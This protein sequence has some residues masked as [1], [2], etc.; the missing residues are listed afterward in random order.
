MSAEDYTGLSPAQ[1]PGPHYLAFY[2]NALAANGIAYDVYD[3]DAHDRTA[4]DPLGVLSHYDA[5]LW[6]TGDDIVVREPDQFGGTSSA[7]RPA[8]AVL[9]PRLHERGRPCGL[10]RQERRL[11][12][13]DRMSRSTTTRSRTATARS[14]P[15]TQAPLCRPLYGS[16]DGVNDV[17]EYWLGAG[18][19]NVGA[20]ANFDDEGNF[21]NAFDVEGVDNPFAGLGWGF[22]GPGTAENQDGNLGPNSYITTSGLVP[23]DEYPQFNSWASAR[24]DRPGGPFDPHSGDNYVYSQIAD[25][26]YKRLTK[27]VTP[28]R[29]VTR[30]RSGPR[31][32]PSPTGTSCSSR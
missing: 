20:G 10:R 21:L 30:C 27:T 5:V 7:A 26:S 17:L 29:R 4:P 11:G 28:R 22:N 25:V 32:T 12:R 16:G 24:Y 8:G 14:Q 15:T 3:V 6:Y 13:H 31:T 23:A 2:E 18:L 9:D 19:V 1:T